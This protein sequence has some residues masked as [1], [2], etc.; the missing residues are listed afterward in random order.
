MHGTETQTKTQKKNWDIGHKPKTEI[1]L[2]QKHNPC[3]CVHC[4][5]LI[6]L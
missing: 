5:V 1:K 4:T 2:G 3:A 6:K